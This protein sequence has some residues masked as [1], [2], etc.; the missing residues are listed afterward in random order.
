MHIHIYIYIMNIVYRLYKSNWLAVHISSYFI[1]KQIGHGPNK[2]L[3]V[4]EMLG[5]TS[6]FDWTQWHP[7]IHTLTSQE[8]Y[9]AGSPMRKSIMPLVCTKEEV[10]K[11]D[12]ITNNLEA[13]RLFAHVLLVCFLHCTVS[14]HS[15]RRS[16]CGQKEKWL[17]ERRLIYDPN[18]R[19][20]GS[21]LRYRYQLGTLWMCANF[22]HL[23][24]IDIYRWMIVI[25]C[26]INVISL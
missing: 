8:I 9:R 21:L 25:S 4:D 17:K 23:G 20:S 5:C 13:I 7:V 11:C 12:E 3:S 26:H 22:E 19:L 24:T 10:K 15:S 16:Q 18:A 6:D 14:S 2:A 1:A